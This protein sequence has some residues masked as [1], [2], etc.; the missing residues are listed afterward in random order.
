MG[1]LPR[2]RP[3]LKAQNVSTNCRGQTFHKQMTSENKNNYLDKHVFVGL[4][5]LNSGFDSPTISYFSE[6]DFEIV[7]DRVERLGLGIQ[8][9]EPWLNGDYFGVV[10]CEDSGLA[11]TNPKWYRDAFKHFK[12]MKED[13]QYS[14]TYFIPDKLL[15][16][17]TE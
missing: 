1:V 16:A 17:D 7:L 9:I 4:K 2:Y 14:A 11:P 15:N 8:G 13:L 10:V 12:D 6:S 5:N 3:S